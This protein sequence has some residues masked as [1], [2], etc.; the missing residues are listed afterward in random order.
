MP[1]C[2]APS[3]PIAVGLGGSGGSEEEMKF[4]DH[5]LARTVGMLHAREQPCDFYSLAGDWSCIAFRSC[6]SA[7]RHRRSLRTQV[8]V[9]C[10]VLLQMSGGLLLLT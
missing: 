1:C 3:I 4:R 9:D 2:E 6:C 10:C 8:A 7:W 5:L